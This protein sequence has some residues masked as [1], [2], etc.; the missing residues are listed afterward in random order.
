MTRITIVTITYNAAHVL[1]RTLDSALQQTYPHVEHLIVDGHSTDDTVRMAR[2]YQTEVAATHPQWTVGLQSEP[3]K[4]LYDAMNKGLQRMTGD[5]V[6]FMNAGDCF[7]APDTLQRVAQCADT[8]PHPAVIYGDTDLTDADGHIIGR[9]RLSP[10]EQL[11]WRSFRHG[12]LVCHQAFY[13]RTDIA[14]A[15]PYDTRYRH[16][17]DVKWCIQ[18]M[19]AAERQQLPLVNTHATLCHYMREGDSTRHHTASLMERLRVMAGEYG[20]PTAIV[21]H[22]WFVVRAIVKR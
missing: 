16:S 18:V 7:A 1:R 3:D 14:R 13:A 21:M 11:T 19:K 9:R 12:M 5:Y 22:A 10:P 17:A 20:W 2:A 15:T 6:V 8:D 4:G